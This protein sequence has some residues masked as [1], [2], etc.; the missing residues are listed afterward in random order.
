MQPYEVVMI[1]L[2][3]TG[4]I[5]LFAIIRLLGKVTK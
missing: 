1:L 4:A 3:I 2:G 5:E